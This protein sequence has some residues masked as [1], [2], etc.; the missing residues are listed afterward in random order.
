MRV[1][2]RILI[3]IGFLSL[4]LQPVFSESFRVR[5]VHTVQMKEEIGF[6]KTVK[7]GINDSIALFLPEKKAGEKQFDF[8]EGFEVK[9]QIPKSV[10]DWRDSVALSLYDDISPRPSE[11]QIDYS[12]TRI[13]IQPLPSKMNWIAQVP[14]YTKTSLKDSSYTTKVSVIPD[15]SKGYAFLRF[16]PVMK[17]VPEETLNATLTVVIKPCLRNLGRLSLDFDRT[18]GSASS[19]VDIL[20][21]DEVVSS[22]FT[23]KNF[24]TLLE[25][26]LHNLSIQS[27]EY[28]SEVRSLVVEQAKVSSEKFSFKSLKPTIS[29]SAPDNSEVFLDGNKVSEIGK[30]FEVSEGEHSLK[31]ILGSYEILRNITAEKG[32]TY[33]ANLNIDLQI[34]ED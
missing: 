34:L 31:F 19:P 16:M 13:F 23:Q 2:C 3:S 30:E 11:N 12:G 24:S 6:E 7:I 20:I 29:I 33:S 4:F 14:L 9:I 28:R 22:Q 17:G 1:L 15:V 27:Q 21:D 8:I 18:E 26:G 5:K 10:S 32:K 25:P